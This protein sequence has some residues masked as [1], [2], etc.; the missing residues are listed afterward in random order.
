MRRDRLHQARALRPWKPDLDR[1]PHLTVETN[2]T[3]NAA[4]RSCY[5]LDRHTVK[6]LGQ[7]KEEIDRGLE[8]RRADAVTLLGG[9]PTLHPD[10]PA[11]VR[12]VA[13]KGITCQVLT[14]GR[15]L[16]D[17]DGHHLLDE[18]RRAGLAR[19]LLHVDEGQPHVH[20]RPLDMAQRL[21]QICEPHDI[22][23]SLSW[24]V[25]RGGA[26]TLP[27]IVRT[28]ARYRHFDGLLLLLEKNC[29][30][31][32]EPGH[33]ADGPVMEDVY[34]AL[35]SRLSLEPSTYLP[36]SLDDRDVSWLFFFYYVN[37]LTGRTFA[38]SP[39]LT[40]A[41]QALFR[42]TTGREVFGQTPARRR[43]VLSL[44]VTLGIEL[45]RAPWRLP[46]AWRLLRRSRRG[47]RLRFHYIVAQDGPSFDEE[48]GAVRICY[49]CPDA[50]IRQ[51]RLTPVCL[52]DR[53]RP[54][55]EARPRSAFSLSLMEAID[56]H[57]S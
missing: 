7:I 25:Y 18:L 48:H 46:Q 6:D 11:I 31:A 38:I 54:L 17:P 10:L 57:L 26:A 43:F 2:F 5:N 56:G 15:R 36:T 34:E 4:C 14:N 1:V 41:F 45:L 27:S 44:I 29:D 16:L 37:A 21:L 30:V 33:A 42:W 47:T 35:W 24:T 39:Q 52:A 22:L 13:S 9:E 49:H 28:L 8:L 55:A 32:I 50:T 20:G 51:G 23:C 19:L 3:C 53:V 12:H 40:R